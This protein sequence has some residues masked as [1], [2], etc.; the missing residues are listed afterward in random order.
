MT[1]HIAVV[2]V[3]SRGRAD[4]VDRQRAFLADRPDVLRVE[5]WLDAAA[6]EPSST[7]VRVHVPPGAQGL[8]VG[9]GRNAAADAAIA[10]GAEML[11]FL[12]ADCLAGPGLIERYEAASRAAPGALLAGPVTYLDEGT[13]PSSVAELPPLTRPHAARPSP[14]DGEV[15]RASD[16]AYDLFWSLSFALTATTWRALGGF[17]EAFQ[18]YGAEDTDFA[19]R[20]R[21]QGVPLVW[22]GGAHA[23]HQW[24]PTSDPPWQHL[25]D[26]LRNGATFARRW[27]RWP[28][29]GWLDKF[30]RDGAIAWD[31]D[32]WRRTTPA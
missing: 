9:E 2:T 26:I 3:A 16:E 10:A 17:S 14:T 1:P 22:V 8:R 21:E 19:W 30:A 27:G 31:G 5:A 32:T 29:G 6:P 4:H 11:I 15:V 7:E 18:G 25:D 12:D 23:Y 28:M 24:H 13:V 20:A